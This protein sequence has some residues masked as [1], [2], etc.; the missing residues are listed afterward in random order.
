M[1]P[2]KARVL[3]VLLRFLAA[4]SLSFFAYSALV[5]WWANPQRI[6]LLL[7]VITEGVTVGLVLFAREARK[8]DWQPLSVTF[9]LVAT[10]YFL[11]LTLSPGTH[12]VPEWFASVM[13]CLGFS[14]QLYAKVS[15]GRSFGLLPADRGVVTRGAYRWV[16]H[17]IYFGYF[18]SHMGF[19]LANFSVQNLL[20][21]AA[22][23]I[24]QTFRILREEAVLLEQ[25]VYRNYCVNVRYRLI[26]F[27]F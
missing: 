15:L 11:A 26:P 17:P 21:Y 18:V 23:Y 24:M 14:W 12:L 20:V 16:R 10:F 6:T 4:A 8:R 19:L 9:T 2:S 5:N 27:V 3:D 25:P 13:Q 22:L 1:T 7:L